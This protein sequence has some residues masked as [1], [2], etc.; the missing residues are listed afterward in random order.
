MKYPGHIWCSTYPGHAYINFAHVCVGDDS[1]GPADRPEEG[2]SD[3]QCPGLEEIQNDGHCLLFL[4]G[5]FSLVVAYI[6]ACTGT[7]GCIV[8]TELRSLLCSVV[9]VYTKAYYYGV[10]LEAHRLLICHS[11]DQA[12]TVSMGLYF[13]TVDKTPVRTEP[14][15]LY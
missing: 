10:Y 5:M 11:G 1:D 4:C 14:G 7:V 12:Y 8:E 9:E 3:G 6:H 15:L 2:H 13:L